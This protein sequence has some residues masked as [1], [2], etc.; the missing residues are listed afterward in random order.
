MTEN[1]NGTKDESFGANF[2][3]ILKI[4]CYMSLIELI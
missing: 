4:A 2:I 3:D 1:C